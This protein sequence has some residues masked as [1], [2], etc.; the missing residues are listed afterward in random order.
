MR[1]LHLVKTSDGA[2]WAALQAEELTKHGVEVHVALPSLEGRTIP[3]WK[4]AG[5][6]I[7]ELATDFP[8]RAPWTLP[9]TLR[10]LRA[11]VDRIRPDIIHSH[12]VGTTLVARYA[13]GKDHPIPRLFQVPGPLHLEHSFYRNWEIGSAGPA[14]RW[15]GSSRC[16]LRHYEAAGIPGDRLFLS[17]YGTRIESFSTRRPNILRARFDLPESQILI[18]NMNYMYPPKRYLGQT[19]GLKGHEDVIDALCE[20]LPDHPDWTG[21]LIGG[22]WGQPPG[23]VGSYEAKLRR[24]AA[25]CGPGRI[26]MPGFLPSHEVANLWADFDLAIH[27]PFSENCGGVV[28][29]ML[30]GVPTIASNVGGLP[31]VVVDEVTGWLTPTRNPQ[32]LSRIIRKAMDSKQLRDIVAT[33]GQAQASRMF[34]VTLT[35]RQIHEIYAQLLYS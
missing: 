17:Y 31:E 22:Q 5:A 8:A 29:P 32:S 15:I 27:V 12:F 21:V 3:A 19:R 30:A 7:H 6:I 18:G 34:N 11:L 25:A 14:D 28:E 13:L 1:V 16:I 4:Q 23:Q 24:R 35:S 2:T 26:L 9:Q 10:S 20:V 33:A